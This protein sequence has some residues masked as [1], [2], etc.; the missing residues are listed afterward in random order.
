MPAAPLPKRARLPNS[1]VCAIDGGLPA[2]PPPPIG[3]ATKVGRAVDATAVAVAAAI[4]SGVAAG[5]D[6]LVAGGVEGGGAATVG[7]GEPGAGIRVR[8]RFGVDASS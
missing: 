4:D 8:T 1:G 5:T 3:R 6:T 2:P 7:S